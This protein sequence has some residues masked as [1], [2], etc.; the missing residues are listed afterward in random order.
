MTIGAA[1]MSLAKWE[2]GTEALLILLVTHEHPIMLPQQCWG[3]SS[4]LRPLCVSGGRLI[5]PSIKVLHASITLPKN[6][7]PSGR[8]I[9]IVSSFESDVC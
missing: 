7:V 8:D 3:V 4:Y 9:I 6:T 5:V 1:N 2:A